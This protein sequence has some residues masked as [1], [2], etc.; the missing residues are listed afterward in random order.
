MKKEYCKDCVCLIE[1]NNE[2]WV[3]DEKG[4]EISKIKRCPETGELEEEEDKKKIMPIINL[5]EINDTQGII[6]AFDKLNERA[7]ALGTPICLNTETS[8]SLVLYF[9]DDYQNR[10]LV[11]KYLSNLKRKCP[12]CGS[13]LAP[14]DVE[15]YAYVCHEC[16]ENFC[17]F[18]VDE[19][20][21]WRGSN[22]MMV[23]D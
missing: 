22:V 14:S 8:T 13:I 1:G 20:E 9:H 21:E 11:D 5:N 4:V 2:E 15:G 10:I 12:R 23:S 17:H 16:D 7:I 18:E 6:D 19:T 3:C